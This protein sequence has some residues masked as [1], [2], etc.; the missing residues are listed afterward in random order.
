MRAAAVRLHPDEAIVVDMV[1]SAFW[2]MLLYLFTL[3]LWAIWRSRHHFVVTNQRVMILTGIVTKHE[4]AVPI[5]RISGR[6]AS[7]WIVERRPGRTVQC[8]RT[9]KHRSHRSTESGA[10]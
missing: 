1:P 8:G 2:T 10:G 6:D 4:M 9:P 5:S 7:P 3:G